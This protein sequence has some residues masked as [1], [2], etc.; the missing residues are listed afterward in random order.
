MMPL[1]VWQ[2]KI[3]FGLKTEWLAPWG[4]TMENRNWRRRPRN[5]IRSANCFLGLR[6]GG[7]ANKEEESGH[8][9]FLVFLRSEWLGSLLAK[10]FYIKAL[11]SYV[12][13]IDATI[14]HIVRSKDQLVEDETWIEIGLKRIL[15]DRIFVSLSFARHVSA[16]KP[17]LPRSINGK[18]PIQ[19]YDLLQIT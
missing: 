13:I 8:R 12:W 9:F 10:G 14:C 11:C 7:W 19:R 3:Q 1:W 16:N 15:K 4:I 6:P 2:R 18:I 17:T 5:F